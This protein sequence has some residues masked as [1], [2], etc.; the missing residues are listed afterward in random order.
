MVSL[1]L[2][3]VSKHVDSLFLGAHRLGFAKLD[4]FYRVAVCFSCS[5]TVFIDELRALLRHLTRSAMLLER[6]RI[7]SLVNRYHRIVLHRQTLIIHQL[8]QF[9]YARVLL[10][11]LLIA[12]LFGRLHLTRENSFIIHLLGVFSAHTFQ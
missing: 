11:L 2:Q 12:C 8:G 3:G 9:Y 4:A 6:R 5:H 10:S 1:A 7:L